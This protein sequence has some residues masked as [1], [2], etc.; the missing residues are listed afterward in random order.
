MQKKSLPLW[1]MVTLWWLVYSV[2]FASSVVSM[3]EE[4]GQALAWTEAFKKSFAGWVSWIP[5]S[6]G[7]IWV[8]S[9]FPLQRK[10]FLKS[11][12]VLNITAF[13]ATLFRAVYV[14][15]TNPFFDWYDR[16]PLFLEVALASFRNNF[17]LAWL[18]IGIAHAFLLSR[19]VRLREREVLELRAHLARAKLKA[20]S[21]QLNPHFLF[22][23][24]NSIA[25]LIHIDQDKADNML[26]SL[27]TLLR[28][29]LNDSEKQEISL[30]EEC[31]LT[32]HYLEIEKIRLADRINVIWKV[33]P[34]CFSAYLPAFVLQPLVENAIV[35]SISTKYEKSD[36]V[37]AAKKVEDQLLISVKNNGSINH[38]K[39]RGHGTGL[40]NMRERLNCLYGVDQ[41]SVELT[42]SEDG[43]VSV[44]IRIPFLTSQITTS[45]MTV[46]ISGLSEPEDVNL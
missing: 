31:E 17:M 8:V 7:M 35:H 6:L 4:S 38:N 44:L 37:I 14:Y 11:F 24:L 25:E 32:E 43:Y 15:I 22:N 46:G 41:S 5:I 2:I 21:A 18:I 39:S 9:K 1:L 30:K 16:A 36:L 19:N 13:L 40:K 20:L 3:S 42:E 45:K 12:L 23:A 33:E 34:V 27:S 29:C 10:H 26:I 28:R